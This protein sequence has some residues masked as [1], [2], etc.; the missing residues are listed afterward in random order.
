MKLIFKS[1]KS[2]PLVVIHRC[3]NS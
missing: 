3:S 2:V 1:S